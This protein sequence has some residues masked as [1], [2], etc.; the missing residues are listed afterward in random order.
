MIKIHKGL[1]MLTK[2]GDSL[3][4][5]MSYSPISM[6]EIRLVFRRIF[7]HEKLAVWFGCVDT[8]HR[9]ESRCP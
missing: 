3:S 6:I 5:D 4:L 2:L 1:S 7:F 8:F 9:N